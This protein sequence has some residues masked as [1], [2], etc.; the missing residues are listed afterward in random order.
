MDITLIIKSVMGLSAI[1]GFLVF[2]LVWPSKKKKKQKYAKVSSKPKDDVLDPMDLPSLL[3]VIKNKKTSSE[4]LKK[5]LDFVIR[6]HGKIHKK[7]GVRT[8]PDF[9]TYMDILFTIC[10][11]PNTNK[12]II[13][14]FDTQLEKLNPQYVKEINDTIAKG[15]NSRGFLGS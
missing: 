4:E 8:H 9:D 10:R 14:D 13:V 1:L 5:A 6:Y 7:L 15:L 3:L 2:L 12:D 11:H